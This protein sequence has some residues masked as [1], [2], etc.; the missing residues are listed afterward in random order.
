MPEHQ[1]EPVGVVG[2]G[3]M[4]GGAARHALAS[5]YQVHGYDVLDTAMERFLEAGGQRAQSPADVARC[6]P[7][8]LI[9]LPSVGAFRDV[10]GGAGSIAASGAA[11]RVVVETSTLPLAEKE[12]AQR[13][14]ADK[15]ITL[16][17]CTLSG[18]GGQM[19]TKDIVVY[20]SGDT[21]AIK[22]CRPILDAFSRKVYDLG[23][24]GNGSRV[25]FIANH[26]VTIHNV[27]A[28]EALVLAKLAGLDLDAVLQAV[29]DGAGTSRMLEVRGPMMIRGD[30]SDATMRL[31]TYQKDLDIISGFGRNL[32]CPL[33]LFAASAE[34]YRAALSQGM[35]AQD[36]ASVFAV[37]ARMAGDG[38][39]IAGT[40][41]PGRG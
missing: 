28:A 1:P 41:Q 19:R 14:L 20:A 16:L 17:D 29:S 27:A 33:P 6:C 10:I 3:M 23:S 11:G 22:R 7:V 13:V 24:F 26:L 39:V 31:D 15:G 5:G 2:L 38:S 4:G 36:A 9:S 30:F 21:A 32:H 25:K 18:T 12:W 37:L 35:A 40:D 8:V 34:L